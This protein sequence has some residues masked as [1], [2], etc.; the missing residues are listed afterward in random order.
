[1]DAIKRVEVPDWDEYS[2]FT[3][4][5]DG[6]WVLKN[7]KGDILFTFESEKDKCL[8][9]QSIINVLFKIYRN[10]QKKYE[11]HMRKNPQCYIPTYEEANWVHKAMYRGFEPLK[12]MEG[13]KPFDNWFGVS[14]YK[15]DVKLVKENGRSITLSLQ[16]IYTRFKF[17][18][19]KEQQEHYKKYKELYE[20]MSIKY[21]CFKENKQIVYEDFTGKLPEMHFIE[22]FINE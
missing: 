3:T 14:V 1:M 10:K 16:G 22:K 7:S 21:I 11:I 15:P 13:F 17:D 20:N 6:K 19:V 5:R 9:A 8:K 4:K 18:S 12:H 2:A